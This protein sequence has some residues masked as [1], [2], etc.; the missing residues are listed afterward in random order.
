L[1][2]QVGAVGAAAEVACI[3]KAGGVRV[4]RDDMSD[5]T[6]PRVGFHSKVGM[7]VP[8]AVGNVGRELKR[9]P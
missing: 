6:I 8:K 2:A 7:E 5:V 1:I 4:M 3:A 9:V